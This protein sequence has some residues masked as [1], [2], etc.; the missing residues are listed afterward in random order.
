LQIMSIEYRSLLAVDYVAAMALWNRTPGVRTTE[1]EAMFNRFLE[2]NPEFSAAAWSGEQLVGAVMCGHDSRRGYLYHLAV[3]EAF[4]RRGIAQ[5]LV[6][7]CLDRLR[8]I[9]IEKCSAFLFTHNATGRDF[10]QHL[11]WR[12]RIDLVVMA[13]DIA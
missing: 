11:G 6:N 7:S 8:T 5:A 4:R 9:G 10:W 1:S 13:K 2:R 12:E 3:E